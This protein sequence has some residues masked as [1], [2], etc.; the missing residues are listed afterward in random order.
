MSEQDKVTLGELN[1]ATLTIADALVCIKE[2][3]ITHRSST[4]KLAMQNA[5]RNIETELDVISQTHRLEAHL[6]GAE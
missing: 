1:S 5:I 4:G 6:A 2:L 3:E